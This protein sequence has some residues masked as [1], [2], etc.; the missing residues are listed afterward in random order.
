MCTSCTD[1]DLGDRDAA[2]TIHPMAGQGLNSGIGDVYSLVK[3]LMDGITH[4][5]DIGSSL[6]LEQY[7]SDRYI[8]NNALLGFVDKL[9]TLYGFETGPIVHLRSLGVEIVNRD[10][11]GL[12]R[13]LMTQAAK[14]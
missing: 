9:H 3:S 12:K 8:P 5:Q 2:H 6:T 7:Q 10:W 11:L 13:F 4:G 14:S 1:A